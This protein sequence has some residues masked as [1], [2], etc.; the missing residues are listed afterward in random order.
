MLSAAK[1]LLFLIEN[2]QK[3]ILRSAQD[4]MLGGFFSSVLQVVGVSPGGHC[5]RLSGQPLVR[6]PWTAVAQAYRHS[7]LAVVSVVFV[8]PRAGGAQGQ[9]P[10]ARRRGDPALQSSLEAATW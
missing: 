7:E 8:L 4:D 1:H 3:Q 5:T 2:K 9:K 10:A 6:A